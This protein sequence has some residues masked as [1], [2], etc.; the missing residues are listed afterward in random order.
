[1][2]GSENRV[3]FSMLNFISF[4]FALQSTT[5]PLLKLLLQ[6]LPHNQ[7]HFRSLKN[8]LTL[9]KTIMIMVSY[10]LC[11]VLCVFVTIKFYD[12]INRV[13]LLHAQRQQKENLQMVSQSTKTFQCHTV[14]MADHFVG[15]I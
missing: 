6:Q 9:N 11:I 7:L 10:T 15:L 14:V 5:S 4:V 2:V 12:Q 8:S 3:I 13:E 1:M